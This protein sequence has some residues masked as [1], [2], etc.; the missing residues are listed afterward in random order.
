[1]ITTNVFLSAISCKM[2]NKKPLINP[3]PFQPLCTGQHLTFS[4]RGIVGKVKI[5]QTVQQKHKVKTVQ[6]NF[7]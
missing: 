1:M 7:S 3:P 5:V 4:C 6:Y 2:I